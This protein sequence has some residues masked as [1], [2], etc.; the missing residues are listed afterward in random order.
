M[1][2]AFDN[3]DELERVR[4]SLRLPDDV[5]AVNAGSWGPLAEPVKRAIQ[6]FAETTGEARY[7]TEYFARHVL[8]C[9]DEDRAAVARFIGAVPEEIALTE[10]TT[11]ALNIFLWGLDLRRD[12]EI[13]FGSLENSAARVPLQ[14]VAQRRGCKL[15]C[16]DVGNGG[17]DAPDAIARALT[18]RSRVV[19]ISDVDFACGERVDLRAVCEVAHAQGALVLADGV[20][21]MGTVPIDVRATGVDAYAV[22]RHK[23]MCGPDGAGALFVRKEIL[24]DIAPTFSGVCSDVDNGYSGAL[25]IKPTAERFEVS[26]RAFEPYVGGTAAIRWFEEEVG[27]EAAYARIGNL[28]VRLWDA[29]QE[30]PRIHV[31]SSRDPRGAL[32]T[33][34]VDGLDPDVIVTAL[35]ESRIYARTIPFTT[36]RS[37]RISLGFWNRE[38]DVE[39]IRDALGAIIHRAS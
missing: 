27:P 36:P 28:R 33:F 16:A 34:H 7:D 9:L 11:T 4:R 22:A 3:P 12:D 26:T 6:A 1:P 17:A 39:G 19:L 13:V 31:L 32:T 15:V 14:V 20:Q 35:R 38:S 10:S 2:V 21:S 5:L 25:R 18:P 37:V 23:F 8:G 30:L 29:L 24:S